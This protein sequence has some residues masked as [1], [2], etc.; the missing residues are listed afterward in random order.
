MVHEGVPGMCVEM[1]IWSPVTILT[2]I[3]H[4]NLEKIDLAFRVTFSSFSIRLVSSGLTCLT[5]I[6]RSRA[7]LIL[8]I[9][10]FYR[11]SLMILLVDEERSLSYIIWFWVKEI[12]LTL[13]WTHLSVLEAELRTHYENES[14]N[15][16]PE[17]KNDKWRH[18]TIYHFIICITGE[19]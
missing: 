15:I 16:N 4:R 7:G 11:D 18:R 14:G 9:R 1:A 17:K 13:T 2:P 3:P 6:V 10:S 12:G 8:Q 19:V 5:H